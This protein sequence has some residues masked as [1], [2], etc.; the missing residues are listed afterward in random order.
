MTY[1]AIVELTPVL[2]AGIANL[3]YWWG[4]GTE[5]MKQSWIEEKCRRFT[6][7]SRKSFIMLWGFTFLCWIPGL[8]A[9]FPGI[10]G[11]DAIYQVRWFQRGLMSSH[12]PILHTYFLGACIT[13]GERYLGSYELGMLL[14]SLIQM[15][16]M[17]FAFAYIGKFVCKKLPNVVAVTVFICGALLP[18]NVLMSFSATKDALF[19]GLF[20]ILVIECYK[21]VENMESFFGSKWRQIYFVGLI[22]LMCAFR[23][24]GYYALLCMLPIFVFICRK[25]WKR[26]LLISVA[27]ICLWNLYTGPVY[28]MLGVEKGR[29]A[30][31]LSVPIQQLARAMRDEQKNLSK[32]EIQEIEE[33][34]PTW[35]CYQARISDSV[36]NTFNEE[37]FDK[38]KL[39]FIRLWVD[40]GLK[41]PRT[42]LDAFASLN[43]GYWYPD[44]IY[45]DPGAWHP[46][47][48][49]N[50]FDK[51]TAD[52]GEYD[53]DEYVFVERTSYLPALSKFYST[54]AY[55]TIAQ[56]V[57]VISMLF[58]P[59]FSFWVIVFAIALC[60]Y[61]K[62]YRMAVPL[63]IL[64]GLWMT[65]I[66]SPVVLMR[67]AYP[68]MISMPVVLCMCCRASGAAVSK[69][70]PLQKKACEDRTQDGV[71][72]SGRQQ[73]MKNGRETED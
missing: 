9:T 37:L 69:N 4:Y 27:C 26:A 38:N 71:R 52:V 12:H 16:A 53:P 17:S 34:L 20:A 13:I 35:D 54:F 55:Q 73:K 1:I 68:M 10:Y 21:V 50:N 3:I 49:Y 63:S 66:L 59:G 14:Y 7:G 43:L 46:Y 2:A 45:R 56:Y 67:Y 28:N 62:Y 8:L 48:E 18:H 65:L 58:N 24:N 31:A 11:Y 72:V 40:V 15:A 22:F 42:Y 29:T 32:D 6:T 36:K 47:M 70:I 23:N 57:P 61:R 5:R 44:M 19:A 64:V 51:A 41:C 60:V 39:E 25:Y 30:E 33:Y